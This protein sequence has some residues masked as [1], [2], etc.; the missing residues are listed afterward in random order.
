MENNMS[1]ITSL[2]NHLVHL[3]E[4][5]R[6][7]DKQITKHYKKRVDDAVLVSE[8][9]EKLELKREITALTK[10]IADMETQYEEEK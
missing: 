1:T 2:S 4:E 8:K 9:L 5:H 7:L 10:R 6:A 3:E